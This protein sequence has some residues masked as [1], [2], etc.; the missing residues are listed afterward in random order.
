MKSIIPI[1]DLAAE[2]N[3]FAK[4]SI[5]PATKRAYESDWANFHRFCEDYGKQSCPA[6]PETVCLYLTHMSSVARISTIT[7]R[8]TSI[9]AIHR[10]AGYDSPVKTDQVGRVLKGIKRKIGKP[11]VQPKAISWDDLNKL[12]EKC[13]SLM[14]GIRDAAILS[15]GW[16]SALRR[17]ELIALNIGDLEFLD[18]GIIINV[19]RSKTDQEG[20]GCKIGIPVSHGNAG[21]CPVIST[22]R[23]IERRSKSELQ[24]EAAKPL[25]TKIGP[26]GRS[27][28]WWPSTERLS[29]RMVSSVVKLYAK[30]A[31]LNPAEY[32][33]HSLRRGLATEAG[34]LGVPERVISR[35]TRHRSVETLRTYIESGTIWTENPLHAVYSAA[36]S[37]TSCQ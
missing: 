28:W 16:A 23:W 19:T 24:M 30:Y 15:L 31:G 34:A 18:Q 21:V 5:S 8:A 35:H 25:F 33:S 22:K 32:S 7:R 3:R 20:K 9:T 13:D 11:P 27:K 1:K 12:I 17:S 29:A 36:R 10:A 2:A 37:I 26:N 4:E 14:L 6:D